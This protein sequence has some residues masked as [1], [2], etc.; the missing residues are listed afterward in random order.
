MHVNGETAVRC[1]L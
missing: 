1:L